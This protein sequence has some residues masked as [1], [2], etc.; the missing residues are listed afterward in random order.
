MCT[1]HGEPCRGRG[2]VYARSAAPGGHRHFMSND[3]SSQ[4]NNVT[5]GRR[6]RSVGTS[7]LRRVVRFTVVTHLHV[8]TIVYVSA[9]S[10]AMTSL[11]VGYLICVS[12]CTCWAA[13]GLSGHQCYDPP[14]AHVLRPPG[15]NTIISW[16]CI[17][18]RAV[19]NTQQWGS[20]A[21]GAGRGHT[22]RVV[23]F[24]RPRASPCLSHSSVLAPPPAGCLCKRPGSVLKLHHHGHLRGT[25]T[26]LPLPLPLPLRHCH[27]LQPSVIR[28]TAHAAAP[29]PH[30]TP[31]AHAKRC[32]LSTCASFCCGM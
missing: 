28:P 17:V 3:T 4:C 18:A 8:F 23:A 13:T 10:C 20:R 30:Y 26:P 1:V 12:V 16:T 14:P 31:R 24:P 27:C 19:Q 6:S 11:L 7:M 22:R 25:P 5:T 32:L 15:R 21:P 2:T 9:I 29:C